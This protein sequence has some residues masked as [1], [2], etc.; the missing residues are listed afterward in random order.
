MNRYYGFLNTF[1]YEKEKVVLDKYTL[2]EADRTR[3][4][5]NWLQYFSPEKLKREFLGCGFL[6]DDLYSDVA[7]TSFD[8]KT[9]EFAVV[10]KKQ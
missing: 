10:A 6:V 5:Y 9:N 1:K 7:G 8:S 4:V 3:T 2:I